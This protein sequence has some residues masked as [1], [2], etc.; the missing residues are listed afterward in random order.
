[1]ASET[2]LV[3]ESLKRWC[4]GNG[5]D[6]G[7]G[8]DKIIPSAIGI[9]MPNPYTHLGEDPVQL[10]GDARNL[11]WF[12]DNVLD[13]VYSSHLLED[14]IDTENILKE[15]LRVLKVGGH[16]VLYLPDEQV[17]SAHCKATGQ[18][19][20]DGHKLA[21]F[22]LD[23]VIKSIEQTGYKTLLIHSTRIINNYSFEIVFKKL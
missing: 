19:H 15:W 16:L 23:H 2:S 9:D 18:P 7:F 22:G 4:V 13:Y 6:L 8:G 3:R 11:Y 20:N 10:G 1:M 14:F 17:Y 5:V 12:K 21:H